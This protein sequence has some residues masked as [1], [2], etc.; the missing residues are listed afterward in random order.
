[1]GWGLAFEYW[2]GM[3]LV[4]WGPCFRKFMVKD[5]LWEQCVFENGASRHLG[6]RG[7]ES[8]GKV[9]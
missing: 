1:M 2:L 3:F 6:D 7:R 5:R 4:S 8:W 9:R